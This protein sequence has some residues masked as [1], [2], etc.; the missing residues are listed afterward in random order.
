MKEGRDGGG[1]GGEGAVAVERD[2]KTGR[3]HIYQKT[4]YKKCILVDISEERSDEL[5]TIILTTRTVVIPPSA[6]RSV[7]VEI[8]L[9]CPQFPTPSI[10]SLQPR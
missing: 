2:G 10:L 7:G 1:G 5:I 3:Q 8:P 4:F 9:D 6:S